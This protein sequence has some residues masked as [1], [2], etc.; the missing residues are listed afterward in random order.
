MP[1][2]SSSARCGLSY[3]GGAVSGKPAAAHSRRSTPWNAGNAH[4][5]WPPSSDLSAFGAISESLWATPSGSSL[6]SCGCCLCVTKARQDSFTTGKE[7][8]PEA[9]APPVIFHL[10][11]FLCPPGALAHTE[12]T[13]LLGLRHGSQLRHPFTTEVTVLLVTSSI[14]GKREEEKELGKET[15]KVFEMERLREKVWLLFQK[16]GSLGWHPQNRIIEYE[17]KQGPEKVKEGWPDSPWSSV[18]IP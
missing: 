14:G 9:V 8:T 11:T 10:L 17:P 15:V 2:H 18:T 13:L 16:L 12:A 1:H 7:F 4:S 5:G 6:P 3:L